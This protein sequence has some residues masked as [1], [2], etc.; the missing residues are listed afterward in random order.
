ME[1]LWVLI[2]ALNEEASLPRVLAA[3][4]ALDGLRVVVCDNGSSDRTAELAREAGALVIHEPQRGYGRA[5]LTAIAEAKRSGAE[6][7]EVVC[8]LDADFSDDPAELPEVIAPLREGRAELVV[9]SR[10]LGNAERGALLPQARFGNWLATRIIRWC[11]GVR[12]SDLGPFRALRM[13]TLDALDMRDE[14][15]GWTVEMQ[16]KAASAGYRCVEVPVSYRRRIGQSKITG[17]IRGTILASATILSILMQWS[18][19]RVG[20]RRAP[21]ASQ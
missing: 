15:F 13:R 14:A 16:L 21:A 18:L 19:A 11:T 20:L 1:R 5:C 9:G 8:F 7:H 12:F 2:P 17:T 10:V 4:P 6:A 3:L